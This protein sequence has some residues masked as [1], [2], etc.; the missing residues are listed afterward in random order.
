MWYSLG[1]DYGTY[2]VVVVVVG[3]GGRNIFRM[4]PMKNAWHIGFK[5]IKLV[6][7]IGF[8]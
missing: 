8:I 5:R 2:F 1:H 3:G 4:F 6:S 7:I